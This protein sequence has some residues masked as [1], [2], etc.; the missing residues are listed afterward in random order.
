MKQGREG[1]EESRKRDGWR[2]K[3]GWTFSPAHWNKKE[4]KSDGKKEAKRGRRE[5]KRKMLPI[6]VFDP[7]SFKK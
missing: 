7:R 5:R 1:N 2:R 3:R 4:K 6:H